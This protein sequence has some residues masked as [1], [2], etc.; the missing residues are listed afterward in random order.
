MLKLNLGCGEM[1]FGEY[2][3]IDAERI[4]EPDL[5]CDLELEQLPYDDS[6]AESVML[7]N[8][9]PYIK[10]TSH[11]FVLSEIWRVLRR[12]GD[13]ILTYNNL[14]SIVKNWS[15]NEQGMRSF[16]ESTIYGRQAHKHDYVVCAID[17]V[18]LC[19][20]LAQIGFDMF[21][22]VQH[23]GMN[24]LRCLKSDKPMTYEDVVKQDMQRIAV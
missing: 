17:K 16:W 1:K 12:G 11:H 15:F 23:E 14:P 21:Q 13:F 18:E 10:R 20:F 3:N 19:D 22:E 4:Y 2:S 5:L 9:L 7:L 6:S 24:G 8:V